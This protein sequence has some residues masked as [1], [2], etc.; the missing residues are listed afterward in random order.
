MFC[1]LEA[2]AVKSVF[3]L[4]SSNI[5]DNDTLG[6]GRA[7]VGG[8]LTVGLVLEYYFFIFERY[9]PNIIGNRWS[10]IT[11]IQVIV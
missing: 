1:E 5:V 3:I 11:G 9:S 6:G 7:L 10:S 2:V 8:W 4:V